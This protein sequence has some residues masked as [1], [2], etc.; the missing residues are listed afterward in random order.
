MEQ[1]QLLVNTLHGLGF[2][3]RPTEAQVTPTQSAEFC[4]TQMNTKKMQFLSAYRQ[5]SIYSASDSIGLVRKRER[6]S[7]NPQFL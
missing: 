3:I 6:H 4:G 5:D 1:T 2:G 7:N